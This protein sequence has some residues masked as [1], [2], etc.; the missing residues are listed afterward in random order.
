MALFDLLQR[1]QG[2][3]PWNLPEFQALLRAQVH[4]PRQRA[5]MVDA[6]KVAGG[7]TKGRRAPLLMAGAVIPKRRASTTEIMQAIMNG[8]RQ[9]RLK[10]AIR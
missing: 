10:K 9:N 8:V 7:L 5:D 6:V 4:Q 1:I 2:G 3:I